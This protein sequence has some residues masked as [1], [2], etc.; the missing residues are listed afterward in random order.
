MPR[1]TLLRN[2]ATRIADLRLEHPVRIAIDGPDAAGKTV[3]ANELEPYLTRLGRPVIRASV[4]GFHNPA[5]M[6]RRRGSL[7]PEG[8][9]CDSFNYS[10]LIQNLLK[11]LGP[12][13]NRIYR[14]AVFDFRTDT[15][16]NPK[17]LEAPTDAILLFDGVFLLRPELREY[18]DFSIFLK[19]DFEVTV[20]RAQTRDLYLFGTSE[21]VL[22]RYQQR[23]VPGQKLYFAE[24]NPEAHATVVIDNTNPAKPLEVRPGLSFT[25]KAAS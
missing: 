25:W 14:R 13:G 2:L 22:E 7:S 15:E 11:P 23:Y 16:L 3:L 10:A 19:V 24:A 9:Y 5:E 4:D 17:R 6:R 21:E 12:G 8:Y 1:A 18:W 20:A